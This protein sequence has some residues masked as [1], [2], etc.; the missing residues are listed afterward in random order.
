ML[1]QLGSGMTDKMASLANSKTVVRWRNREE[2]WLVLHMVSRDLPWKLSEKILPVVCNTW[3][4]SHEVSIFLPAVL[5]ARRRGGVSG[6][7]SPPGQR[8]HPQL[9]FSS[10]QVVGQVRLTVNVSSS[11]TSRYACVWREKF[12]PLPR[13]L[14]NTVTCRNYPDV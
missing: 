8:V 3:C 10:K 7:I 12:Q 6:R 14:R 2:H 1:R 9:C 11:N 4:H 13:S 5:A